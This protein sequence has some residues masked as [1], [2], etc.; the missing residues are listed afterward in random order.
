MLDYQIVKLSHRHTEG[1]SDMTERP[2]DPAELD[3]ERA[4]AAGAR[5]FR[6]SSC[7][8]EVAIQ[9]AIDAAPGEAPPG[10]D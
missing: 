6:C 10:S 2:H 5:I 4:W 9:P 1:W 8:A 3:P 7:E